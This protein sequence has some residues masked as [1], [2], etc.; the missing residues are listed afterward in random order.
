MIGVLSAALIGVETGKIPLNTLQMLWPLHLVYSNS[1][2]DHQERG[3]RHHHQ[4]CHRRLKGMIGALSAPLLGVEIGQMPFNTLQMLLPLHLVC[5]NS[6]LHH[7]EHRC[8]CHQLRHHCLVSM[9]LM[10]MP[11]LHLGKDSTTI[12]T[13]TGLT[14]NSGMC[15]K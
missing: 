12:E 3:S 5:S 10:E 4:L 7:Q 6:L 9:Y 1:L 13:P 14:G 15:N 11:T 2:L 8:H